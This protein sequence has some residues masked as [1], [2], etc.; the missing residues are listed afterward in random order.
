MGY[1]L[2][3]EAQ[4]RADRDEAVAKFLNLLSEILL[5]V[6]PLILTAIKERTNRK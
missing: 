3:Y 5:A 2:S 6:K 1:D 4:Q